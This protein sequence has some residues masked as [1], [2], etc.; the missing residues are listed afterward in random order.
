VTA[1]P[2]AALLPTVFARDRGSRA[3]RFV[4]PGLVLVLVLLGVAALLVGHGDLG[5]TALR[6]TLL[7]LRTQRLLGAIV[8]G[9]SLA[10]AGVWAQGL[11]RNPLA[12]PSLLGTTAGAS[13]GGQAAMMLYQLV[14]AG[15]VS[16]SLPPHVFLPIGCLLGGL[17]ALV[18]LLAIARHHGDLVLLLLT[19]FILSAFFLGLG[20][21]LMSMAQEKWELGRAMVAFVLGGLSGTSGAQ[22]A[23]AWPLALGGLL[24]AWLWGRGLD[25]LLSGE[26][27]AAALGADVPALRR[28]GVVW[29][30]TLTAAAVSLGGN[31]GFVGLVV[32]HGL[33]V[34]L[35]PEHRR[36]VPAAALAGAAFVVACDV[37]ARAIPTRTELPLGVVTGL[38]GAPFFLLVLLRTWRGAQH[39]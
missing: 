33:R 39:V 13:F 36:L 38:I 7:E 37:L 6:D 17:L 9:A 30:A 2:D 28:W 34:V 15:Q 27:E 18:V 31:V 24:A 8:T 1:Q 22:V 16:A 35:G 14:L 19:G 20:N 26:E 23:M 10:V 32:P 11:F 21:F 5:D 3:A 12:D 25:L 29:C 4:Y